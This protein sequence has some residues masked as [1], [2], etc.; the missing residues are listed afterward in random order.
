MAAK[1]RETHARRGGPSCGD[2]AHRPWVTSGG[3]QDQPPGDAGQRCL[4]SGVVAEQ[5][6]HTARGT[7]EISAFR[8]DLKISCGRK[9]IAARGRGQAESPAF[10]APLRLARGT[11]FSGCGYRAGPTSAGRKANPAPRTI[12]AMAHV[13]AVV[14][15]SPD[16]A[17]LAF[18]RFHAYMA[19]MAIQDFA[20]N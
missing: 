10:R 11:D 16:S 17:K 13:L 20:C 2:P 5:A 12:R 14:M 19:R 4:S 1:G 7:P 9:R 3:Y 15:A 18:A 6:T 8:G